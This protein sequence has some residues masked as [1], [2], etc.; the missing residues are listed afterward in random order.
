MARLLEGVSHIPASQTSS[1]DHPA[2]VALREE[3]QRRFPNAG[4]KDGLNFALS[5]AVDRLGMSNRPQAEGFDIPNPA[6]AAQQLEAAF[7][8][9]TFRRTHLCPLDVADEFPDVTFG[10]NAVRDLSAEEFR[11]L[12]VPLG[13]YAAKLDPRLA[14]FRWLIVQE[15]VAV[16]VEPGHRALPFLFRN[17]SEDFAKIEPHEKKFPVAVEQALFALLLA[18]WEDLVGHADINWRAFQI[19]WSY[20]IDEDLFTRPAT[21]PSADSLNWEPDFYRDEDGEIIEEVERPLAYH[22]QGAL[23]GIETWVNDTRWREIAAVLGSP[24]FSTPVSHF[25]VAAF[26]VTGIDE[27]IGHLTSL[28]AAL[29]LRTDQARERTLGARVAALLKDPAAA[30]TYSRLFNLRSEYVHGRP[31]TAIS[32][33]DRNDA[34]RLA[35]Q[36]AN[37]L[38]ELAEASI[39]D[40]QACLLTLAPHRPPK[41]TR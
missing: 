6:R 19:P 4:S 10:P 18:P 28:E 38:V 23:E 29:G 17:M 21:L 22:F 27:F 32:G 37:A 3:C 25:L 9:A 20:T 26:L 33:E 1:F 15:D 11:N 41:S 8:A 24:L 39:T 34:R 12:F 14:Q 30:A 5:A 31:M 35:R 36:V 40:R 13:S 16:E 7:V 2:F